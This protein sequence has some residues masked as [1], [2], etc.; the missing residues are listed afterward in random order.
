MIAGMLVIFLLYNFANR[1]LY[2]FMYMRTKGKRL[3]MVVFVLDAN[4]AGVEMVG[5]CWVANGDWI[6][7]RSALWLPVVNRFQN[8]PAV[9]LSL[10]KKEVQLSG[11]VNT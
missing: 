10:D 11:E 2:R 3:M 7:T 1:F 4:A 5:Y 8:D 6:T 9:S